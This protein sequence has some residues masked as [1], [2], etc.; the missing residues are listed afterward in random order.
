M[1]QRQR[2]TTPDGSLFGRG[3]VLA[4]VDGWLREAIGGRFRLVLV[5]GP[6]GIGKSALLREAVRSATS[7]GFTVVASTCHEDVDA[8]P[9]A[10]DADDI[11]K[12]CAAGPV[13]LC[14][15]DV[16][17]A[18]QPTLDVLRRIASAAALTEAQ[19]PMPL[20]MVIAHRP[21]L[22]EGHPVLQRLATEHA[23]RVV[24]L[25][26]LDEL[27]TNELITAF[28]PAPPA[29]ALLASVREATGGN[30]L[31]VRLGLDRMLATGSVVVKDGQLVGASADV[32]AVLPADLDAALLQWVRGIS[33]RG[34]RMLLHAAVLGDGGRVGELTTICGTDDVVELVDAGLLLVGPESYSFGHPQLREVVLHATPPGELRAVHLAVADALEALGGSARAIAIA[35]HLGKAGS[36]V[37]P[38]R[39]VRWC[40]QAGAEALELGA[41]AAAARY[42]EASLDAG[43]DLGQDRG[44]IV[45]RAARAHFRN[46]DAR[47]CGARASEAIELARKKDT[48]VWGEA[49]ALVVQTRMAYGPEVVGAAVDIDLVDEFLTTAADV[50]ERQQAEL[51]FMLAE[52]HYVG[53][54]FEG[55]RAAAEVGLEAASE[56]GDAVLIAML[57]GVLGLVRTALLELDA[58][59]QHFQACADFAHAADNAWREASGFTRLALI[60]CLRGDAARAEA[61]GAKASALVERHGDW[62]EY[63]LAM[64]CRAAAAALHG[65]FDTVERWGD[66]SRAAWLRSDYSFTPLVLYPALA[67]ARAARG[68]AEGTGQ[69]LSEWDASGARGAWAIRA[70]AGGILDPGAI[71]RDALEALVRLATRNTPVHQF[72]L[73][74][75]CAAVEA[76]HLLGGS[77]QDD[78]PLEQLLDR[79]VGVNLGWPMSVRRL[80]GLSLSHRGRID[81]AERWLRDALREAKRQGWRPEAGRSALDLASLLLRTGEPA[82]TKQAMELLIDAV[83]VFDRLGMMPFVAQA[84]RLAHDARNDI[85]DAELMTR[86]VVVSDLV[87]STQ[88][89][90]SVGDQQYVRLLQEHDRIVRAS[91]RAF[92]GVEFK[93][94]GDGICSWFS[95][96]LSAV[97]CALGLQA[98]LDRANVLHPEH[99]LRVR[100]GIAAG[101]PVGDEGDLFGITV[102]LASRVCAVAGPGEV[103]LTDDAAYALGPDVIPLRKLNPVELKGFPTRFQLYLAE[104]SATR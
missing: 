10:L 52:A 4:A 46:S 17:W 103:L 15:D 99:P 3:A 5:R 38:D 95:S 8:R 59:E 69:A 23:A 72:R 92:D 71:D 40:L 28:S 18:D 64:S 90:L 13:L 53:F 25:P 63:S 16:Q 100:A 27:G 45:V 96:P 81:D 80:I 48:E 85:S 62:A 42:Y 78:A 66:D 88:L 35:D 65:S 84:R 43:T 29:P 54:D 87:D 91:L 61:H 19:G 93:H 102:A 30:P 31:F 20:V 98:D 37:D 104:R 7:L 58:A 21:Q 101:R 47:A 14:V 60:S 11:S 34:Y 26:G 50:D 41:W 70:L 1:E 39:L 74:G 94:T 82:A 83:G 49:V 73:T 36:L 97:Q 6:A 77:P 55:A 75:L 2:S 12:A 57:E 76:A 9:L 44:R 89:N 67:W 24:E 79:G 51:L 86:Y 33:E 56:S 32:S 68:D 22:G